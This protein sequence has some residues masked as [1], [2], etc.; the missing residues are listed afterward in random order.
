MKERLTTFFVKHRYVCLVHYGY[1]Q[2]RSEGDGTLTKY[3]SNLQPSEVEAKLHPRVA[4]GHP[5]SRK[6]TTS[7]GQIYQG[8]DVP[9]LT[10][11]CGSCKGGK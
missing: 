11:E 10:G 1:S 6:Q 3:Q 5:S 7:Q 4:E 2:D 9:E 8:G